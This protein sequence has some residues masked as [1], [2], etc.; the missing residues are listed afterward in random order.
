MN[1]E[2]NIHFLDQEKGD[3]LKAVRTLITG[4]SQKKKKFNKHFLLALHLNGIAYAYVLDG[5][6]FFF[7]DILAFSRL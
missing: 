2:K 7:I 5:K 3:Q 4:H 6:T 1:C